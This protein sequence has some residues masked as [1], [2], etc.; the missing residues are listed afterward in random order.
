MVQQ[1]RSRRLNPVDQALSSSGNVPAP[2]T[3]RI[4]IAGTTERGVA[5]IGKVV[6]AF[7]QK[8]QQANDDSEL[9]L[10]SINTTN[11]VE[12]KLSELKND[13]QD[14]KLFTK[15]ANKELNK[16]LNIATKKIG[17]RNKQRFKSVI[18]TIQASSNKFIANGHVGKVVDMSKADLESTKDDN[19]E[20]MLTEGQSS[21]DT[22]DILKA[23]TSELF[24][25]GVLD[26]EGKFLEDRKFALRA[27][28]EEF[29]NTY[30][31]DP[32]KALD[33]INNDP[34]LLAEQKLDIIDKTSSQVSKWNTEL[35]RI[36]KEAQTADIVRVYN[37][38]LDGSTDNI[39][40]LREQ[41]SAGKFDYKTTKALE[42][43]FENKISGRTL[44]DTIAFS[45]YA[46][47][48]MLNPNIY[49]PTQIATL[50]NVRPEKRTQL[51]DLQA[52]LNSVPMFNS[53]FFKEGM[54]AIETE[55][56][57]NFIDSVDPTRQSTKVDMRLDFINRIATRVEAETKL[58]NKDKIGL[59]SIIREE[60]TTTL[61]QI[62]NARNTGT[63][64]RGEGQSENDR[65]LDLM[66]KA[67]T[68]TLTD[69]EKAE[70]DRELGR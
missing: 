50:T 24:Q 38:I 58:K 44:E 56:A 29:L 69:D 31:E 11:E 51:L 18:A 39:G 36:T 19:I 27:K 40:R 15:A 5:N 46:N 55:F 23:K 33:K 47:E 64:I 59:N 62:R 49:S 10:A 1:K 66:Q 16:I 67:R 35:A 63:V 32:Q 13:I 41:M 4:A 17:F 70:M 52:R 57:R 53:P 26:A 2:S 61:D 7:G 22:I 42:S 28:T 21:S 14:P 8:V 65:R 34:D 60:I 54:R 3:T 48:I 45:A 68:G 43:D 20:E 37:S 30:K 9:S 12:L 6:A 25:N